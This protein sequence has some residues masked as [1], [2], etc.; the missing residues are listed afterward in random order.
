MTRTSSP[1]STETRPDLV[2]P[3][4]SVLPL[5]MGGVIGLIGVVQIITPIL[6]LAAFFGEGFR[7]DMIL[8][9]IVGAVGATL[10]FYLAWV[11]LSVPR[12]VL[13]FRADR[14]EIGKLFGKYTTVP[15]AE[16]KGDGAPCPGGQGP[17]AAARAVGAGLGDD[18]RGKRRLASRTGGAG[19]RPC[20]NGGAGLSPWARPGGRDL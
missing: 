12:P 20:R 16:I 3:G 5:V 14:V 7:D 1:T 17:G 6:T 4:R 19:P 9:A 11:V 8:N 2:I 15:Y 18:G 13:V 10:C